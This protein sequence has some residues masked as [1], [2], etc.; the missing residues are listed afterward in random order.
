[1]ESDGNCAAGEGGGMGVRRP[2]PSLACRAKNL[3]G[4]V[5]SVAVDEGMRRAAERKRIPKI[6]I[7]K[8][9]KL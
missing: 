5:Y 4:C 7:E 1:M 8:E 6:N 3:P 2:L 9:E